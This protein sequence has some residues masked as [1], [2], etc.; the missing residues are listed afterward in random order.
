MCGKHGE[1]E[2]NMEK[3]KGKANCVNILRK[4]WKHLQNYII[5]TAQKGRQISLLQNWVCVTFE[6][7]GAKTRFSHIEKSSQ[8]RWAGGRGMAAFKLI[9]GKHIFLRFCVFFFFCILSYTWFNIIHKHA[10]AAGVEFIN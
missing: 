10:N 9:V 6:E 5:Y 8:K 1:A 2:R 3:K 7:A 4:M